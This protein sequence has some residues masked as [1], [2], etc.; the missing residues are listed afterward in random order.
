VTEA[1]AAAEAA[2]SSAGEPAA[3]LAGS[4][5]GLSESLVRG[6][7]GIP[8]EGPGF[9]GPVATAGES[10]REMAGGLGRATTR[11]SEASACAQASGAVDCRDGTMWAATV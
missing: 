3:R 1:A 2:G 9:S 7:G 8:G 4:F 11:L 5:P 6:E 10:E